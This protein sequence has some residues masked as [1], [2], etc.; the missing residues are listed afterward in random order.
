MSSDECDTPD[1][2]LAAS[3]AAL[4]ASKRQG[5]G[6][7]TV[8]DRDDNAQVARRMQRESDL[9]RA[10]RSDEIVLH[11][12]PF[13]ALDDSTLVG[14]E[15]LV[16]WQHPT[17]GPLLPDAFLPL[18]EDTALIEEL[19]AHVLDRAVAHAASWR[20]EGILPRSFALAVNVGASQV[21]TGRFAELVDDVLRRHDW[22]ASSLVLELTERT[23]LVDC[24]VAR[25]ELGRLAHAG[26]KVAID[27]FG[28]G[29]SSL[30]YVHRLDVDA[31]KLDRSLVDGIGRSAQ[32]N[33][34]AKAVA[35]LAEGLG[36]TSIVEGVETEQ[37]LATARALGFDWVQGELLSP[38]LDEAS[39]RAHLR[40]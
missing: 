18:A 37:Q 34:V 40:R 31:I 16:R 23:L 1:L 2:L 26:V 22:P 3:G 20:A 13:Y 21:T 9:R 33:A 29:Y 10:L 12:Q 27:D 39:L 36:L 25:R 8:F 14:V 17:E 15:T 30:S 5:R 38:A 24:D 19:G 35:T 11:F 28:T 32:A 6:A 7:T 4:A